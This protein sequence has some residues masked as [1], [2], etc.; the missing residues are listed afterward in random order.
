MLLDAQRFAERH[1]TAVLV[2]IEPAAN[3]IELLSGDG[4]WQRSLA[5][6]GSLRV[7]EPRDV[8]EAVVAE[9]GALPDLQVAFVTAD[10]VR[11]GFRTDPLD[12]TF[13]SWS[14]GN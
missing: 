8:L 1:R 14:G 13:E 5:L 2:R 10:N 9:G 3:R 7:A 6:P 12:G 11:A 4:R